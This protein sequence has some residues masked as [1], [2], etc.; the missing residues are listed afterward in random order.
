MAVGWVCGGSRH[1]VPDVVL[2]KEVTDRGVTA[3]RRTEPRSS[4]EEGAWPDEL[5]R[6]EVIYLGL[7]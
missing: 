5:S 6:R 1:E 2:G 7:S 4:Q 3:P